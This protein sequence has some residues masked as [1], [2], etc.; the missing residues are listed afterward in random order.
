MKGTNEKAILMT[1][2]EQRI[3]QLF[4]NHLYGT[5]NLH[6]QFTFNV[7]DIIRDIFSITE[8]LLHGHKY[9]IM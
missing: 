3:R 1:W 9:F 6:Y 5:Q 7:D 8:D 2:K 4:A